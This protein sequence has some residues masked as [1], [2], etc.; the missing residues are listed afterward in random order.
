MSLVRL[1]LAALCG[2]C[3]TTAAPAIA[4]HVAPAKTSTTTTAPTTTTTST[5][6]TTTTTVAPATTTTSTTSTTPTTTTTTTPTTT[7]TATTTT[8]SS[9]TVEPRPFAANSFWNTQI[10]ATQT[11]DPYSS[12]LVAELVRQV[13]A[14]GP[15]MNTTKYSTPVYTVDGSQPRVPVILDSTT[16]PDLLADFAAGAPLPANATGAAGTDG[17]AVV[18]QPS[19]DTMWEFWQLAKRADGWHA[20]WG[21]VMQHVSQSSG[22]FPKG[23]GSSASSLA[24]MGGLIRPKEFASWVIPHALSIGLPEIRSWAVTSPA[25]RTDGKFPG[26]IPIGTRFQIDPNINVFAL[27]IPNQ[28]KIL[29]YA[30]QRYGIIVSD[31]AGAVTFWGEDPLTMPSNPWPNLINQYPDSW[32]KA[33]PWDKLRALPPTTPFSP[34]L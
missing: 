29:A 15:W 6:P 4:K 14:Y 26:G 1:L 34:S 20:S 7:T 21:G 28:A 30:A 19:T 18:W 8:T 33:F 32:L 23:L 24:L 12:Q 25:L 22:V 9:S 16:A 13:N 31:T 3:L 11:S 10:P 2:L 27:N 17:W 5:A